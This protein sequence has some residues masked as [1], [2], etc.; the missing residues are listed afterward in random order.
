MNDTSI[1][2]TYTIPVGDQA[3]NQKPIVSNITSTPVAMTA[4]QTAISTL[5]GIDRDGI[6]ASYMIVSIPPPYF[7]TLYYNDGSYVAANIVGWC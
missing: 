5:T 7:G 6:I 4:G 2:A 1:I 3:E